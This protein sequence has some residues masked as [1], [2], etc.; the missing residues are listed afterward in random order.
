MKLSVLAQGFYKGFIPEFWTGCIRQGITFQCLHKVLAGIKVSGFELG[1]VTAQPQVLTF[2]S[3]LP[4]LCAL[5]GFI[6][7]RP[8]QFRP[9]NSAFTG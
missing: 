3:P 5:L 9:E 1:S 6:F 8:S 4:E 2:E 7:L